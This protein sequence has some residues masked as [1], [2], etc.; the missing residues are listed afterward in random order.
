MACYDDK[1]VQLVCG[2]FVTCDLHI[3]APLGAKL[4]PVSHQAMALLKSSFLLAN[5]QH[6]SVWKGCWE[7]EGIVLGERD[8]S[9]VL[10]KP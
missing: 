8:D 10:L 7:A 9:Q 6:S 3:L 1:Q 4:R 2:Y 5:R